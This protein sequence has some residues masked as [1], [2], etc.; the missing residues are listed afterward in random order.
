MSWSL[1]PDDLDITS[2]LDLLP[3]PLLGKELPGIDFF[4]P[5]SLSG[6]ESDSGVNWT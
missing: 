2:K 4:L 3:N 1:P 6:G 5:R